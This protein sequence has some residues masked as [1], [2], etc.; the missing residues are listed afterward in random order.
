MVALSSHIIGLT[1]ALLKSFIS[2][3]ILAIVFYQNYIVLLPIFLEKKKYIKYFVIVFFSLVLGVMVSS[4]IDILFFDSTL[5][6]K[7]GYIP[8]EHLEHLPKHIIMG[9]NLVMNTISLLATLFLSTIFRGITQRQKEEIHKVELKNKIVEAESKFLKSQI[10]PHFIF[11]ALNNIYSLSQIQS[12]KT[13]EAIHKLSQILRYVIYD[14]SDK[15]VNIERELEYI[16]SF[17]DLQKMKDDAIGENITIN[18]N[19]QNKSIKIAPMLL[20]PFIENSFKHS[21]IEDTNNGW[22]EIKIETQGNKL[23]F[24][25]KN[26]IPQTEIKK[27]KIGGI[28][29][30]NVKKRLELL[31]PDNY[32][33]DITQ[34]NGEFNVSLDIEF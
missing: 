18:I 33:L 13:P 9:R 25:C 31:Y 3:F 19:I 10:N 26:S 32:K 20:I 5:Y 7:K 16:N 14:N 4:Y 27:D 24:N 28:G 1:N 29:L 30:E 6:L 21:Y 15:F 34:V 11:N 23:Y 17:I 8:K 12:P 2:V 22:I